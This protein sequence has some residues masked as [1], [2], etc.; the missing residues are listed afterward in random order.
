MILIL[1]LYFDN[2]YNKSEKHIKVKYIILLQLIRLSIIGE[3]KKYKWKNMKMI[4]KNNITYD[5][6]TLYEFHE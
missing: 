2:H 3:G 5:M 4:Q 1:P 6:I